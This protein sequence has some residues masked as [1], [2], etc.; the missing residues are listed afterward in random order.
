MTSLLIRDQRLLYFP[1][2]GVGL[3][4]LS[5]GAPETGLPQ[6]KLFLLRPLTLPTVP[7]PLSCIFSLVR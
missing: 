1:V 2:L 3:G 7:C 4:A 5:L 6:A